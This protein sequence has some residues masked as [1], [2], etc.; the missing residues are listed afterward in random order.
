MRKSTIEQHKDVAA[1]QKRWATL[2]L[3]E[4]MNNLGQYHRFKK[5]GKRV[6]AAEYKKEFNWDYSWYRKRMRDANGH[7]RKIG[8]PEYPVRPNPLR[9]RARGR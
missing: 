5:A 9:N 2:A 3:K 8:R 1:T 4:G 7:R 6:E